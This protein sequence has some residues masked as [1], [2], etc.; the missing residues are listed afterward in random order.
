[1]FVLFLLTKYYMRATMLHAVFI[2]FLTIVQL[3]SGMK[4]SVETLHICQRT[5]KKTKSIE[6]KVVGNNHELNG[7]SAA[8]SK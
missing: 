8:Y 1:M 6:N 7:S 5:L 2:I 3:Y 4:F